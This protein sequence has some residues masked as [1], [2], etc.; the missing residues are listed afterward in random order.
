MRKLVLFFAFISN[1]NSYA[2]TE[3]KF[4]LNPWEDING[5]RFALV[6]IKI[7]S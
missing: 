7:L 4:T 6:T 2:Q 3:R 5:Y 1:L